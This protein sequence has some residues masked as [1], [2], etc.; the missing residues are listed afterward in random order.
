MLCGCGLRSIG[1]TITATREW[2][3]RHRLARAYCCVRGLLGHMGIG[4]FL[5]AVG[6]E[7]LINGLSSACRTEFLHTRFPCFLTLICDL[8]LLLSV[9][10]IFR[11]IGD[12]SSFHGCLGTNNGHHKVRAVRRPRVP[13]ER[14]KM[15]QRR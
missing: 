12:E 9:S 13:F 1:G 6:V 4:W 10:D 14:V 5:R 2:H 3:W 15:I 11:L 7:L 8:F